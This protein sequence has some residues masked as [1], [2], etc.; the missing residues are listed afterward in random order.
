MRRVL[1]VIG[2]ILL[3]VAVV[4]LTWA[5]Q[6][7]GIIDINTNFPAS[8]A[9]HAT[10]TPAQPSTAEAIGFT[11]A[12]TPAAPVV[13]APADGTVLGTMTIPRLG[14]DVVDTPVIQGIT[15]DVLAQGLGH[16]PETALPG[17]QGNFA[18]AGHRATNGEELRNIDQL[19]V[20]DFVFVQTT[21]NWYIYR[22]FRD[23]IVTP[24]DYWVVATDPFGNVPGMSD[25]LL[26]I[27][28]CHPRWGSAERWIWWGELV[29]TL[30][31][32][33]GPPPLDIHE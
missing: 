2:G 12:E 24:E 26:T 1:Q 28:T 4:G 29:N 23:R 17:Q 10:P 22:L 31:T 18:L 8:A 5:A 6:L 20:G 14:T 13:A 33:G 21:D 9:A 15:E 16:F 30:P 25:H 3:V 11:A 27:T 19:Q 7:V 32:A